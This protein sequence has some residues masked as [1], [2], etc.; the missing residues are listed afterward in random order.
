VADER[1]EIKQARVRKSAERKRCQAEEVAEGSRT[2]DE[3]GD[4]DQFS[5]H[6]SRGVL[7]HMTKD[8]EAAGLSWDRL[9]PE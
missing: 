5:A 2:L 9:R 8:E 4:L 6:A 7:R 3:W 1:I